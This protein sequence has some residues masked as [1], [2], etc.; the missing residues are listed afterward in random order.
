MILPSFEAAV[1]DEGGGE[2]AQHDDGT[3]DHPGNRGPGLGPEVG[4]MD[5]GGSAEL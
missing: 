1:D 2:N 3:P 5:G 4:A